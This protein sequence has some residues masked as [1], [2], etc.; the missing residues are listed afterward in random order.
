VPFTFSFLAICDTIR[1]CDVAVQVAVPKFGGNS[2]LQFAGLGQSVLRSYS[3]EVVFLPTSGDGLLLYNG[4]R[5]P[6]GSPRLLT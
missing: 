3:V 2:Y 5:P 6:T 4:S 1:H